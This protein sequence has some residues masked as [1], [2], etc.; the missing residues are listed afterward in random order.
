MLQS[1]ALLWHLGAIRRWSFSLAAWVENGSRLSNREYD[2]HL[3][4]TSNI[5]AV[6]KMH[7][8]NGANGE[9]FVF[10]EKVSDVM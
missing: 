7:A 8:L 5:T 2:L 1:K 9:T 10:G 6:R 4:A 3:G